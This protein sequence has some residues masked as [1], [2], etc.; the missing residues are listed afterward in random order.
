MRGKIARAVTHSFMLF[1]EMS[2]A[3]VFSNVSIDTKEM[4]DN[5][6]TAIP[7]TA[8]ADHMDAA[9]AAPDHHRVIF[10]NEHVRVLDARIDPG[11]K[12]PVH[13]HRWPSVAYTLATNDFVRYDAAGT[14]VLDSR[15]ADIEVQ[16]GSVV[17]LPP[18]SEHSVENVG[19]GE[20][21]AL[22]VELK[23]IT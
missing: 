15:N 17:W 4:E 9:A 3:A 13:T 6:H 19:D 21:R 22:V 12:V 23:N 14:I 7:A 5:D 10:E 2:V 18:L 8:W 20:I 11:E 1:F 16:A